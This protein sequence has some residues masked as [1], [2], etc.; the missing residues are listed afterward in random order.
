M[1][2]KERNV[3]GIILSILGGVT[4]ILAISFVYFSLNGQNYSYKY[5][6][7]NAPGIFAQSNEAG[8]GYETINIPGSGG[9]TILIKTD[10]TNY[11]LSD[12]EKDL[13]NYTSVVLKIYNLHNIPFTSITPKIQVKIDDIA[14]SLEVSSGNIIISDGYINNP[15]L[16]I[17]TTS[18][19][20]LNLQENNI[21]VKDSISSGKIR[22]D[23]VA[24]KFTLFA[25]GYLSL[26]NQ[27][28]S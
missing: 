24:D 10:V 15:D 25:K 4:L 7:V 20:L 13:I 2:K 27:L 17:T 5:S 28:S 22:I 18:Q 1:A 8:S 19:D 21:S 14:Y 16:M 11:S 26:F 9:K 3:P 6:G 12:I 23:Q